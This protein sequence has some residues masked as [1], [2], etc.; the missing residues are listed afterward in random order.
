VNIGTSGAEIGGAFGVKKKLVE[1]EKV[2]AIPGKIICAGK[3]IR[4]I[5]VIIFR[6]HRVLSLIFN[7]KPAVFVKCCD[8]C[9]II[10]TFVR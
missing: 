8:F 6:W 9:E 7:S 2:A 4:S 10:S 5:S 1:A 3:R